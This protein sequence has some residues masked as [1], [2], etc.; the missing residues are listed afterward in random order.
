MTGA[1]LDLP[2]NDNRFRALDRIDE[3]FSSSDEPSND[4][5]PDPNDNGDEG[6]IIRNTNVDTRPSLRRSTRVKKPSLAG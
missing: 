5:P 6:G 2:A 1:R 3:A 4:I